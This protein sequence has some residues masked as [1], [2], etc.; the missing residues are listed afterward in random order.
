[1]VDSIYSD[2]LQAFTGQVFKGDITPIVFDLLKPTD[3]IEEL[4]NYLRG[5]SDVCVKRTSQIS[6]N[7]G[8]N[9]FDIEEWFSQFKQLQPL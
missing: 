3:R 9:R 4:L 8:D 2:E 1:M 7:E 5:V 6:I